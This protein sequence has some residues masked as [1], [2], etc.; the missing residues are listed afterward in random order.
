MYL[1]LDPPQYSYDIELEDDLLMKP[2]HVEETPINRTED[3]AQKLKSFLI[4]AGVPS[5]DEKL[6][7]R[8]LLADST[9][10][11]SRENAELSSFNDLNNKPQAIDLDQSENDFIDAYNALTRASPLPNINHSENIS[12]PKRDNILLNP[13]ADV[14]LFIDIKDPQTQAPISIINDNIGI[15]SINNFEIRQEENALNA[16]NSQVPLSNMKEALNIPTMYSQTQSSR[17]ENTEKLHPLEINKE[18]IGKVNTLNDIVAETNIDIKLS[19]LSN[20]GNN[21]LRDEIVTETLPKLPTPT[22]YED[23]HRN[24]PSNS[25][26]IQDVEVQELQSSSEGLKQLEEE[27]TIN[28]SDIVDNT[29]KLIQQMKE[30]INSDINS[31]DERSKSHSEADNSSNESDFT[32]EHESSYSES[33]VES[34]DLTSDEEGESPEENND[35]KAEKSNTVI[36][37]TSSEENDQFEEAMDHIEEQNENF[38]QTNIEILDSI[39]RSLQEEQSISIEYMPNSQAIHQSQEGHGNSIE[40]IPK[41][42]RNHESPKKSISIEYTPN[43]Q[44]EEPKLSEPKATKP[45]KQDLNNNLFAA[46]NSFEEIYEQ[47]ASPSTSTKNNNQSSPKH[48]SPIK[49]TNL[50]NPE[51]KPKLMFEKH[52]VIVSLFTQKSPTSLMITTPPQP[53]AFNA[54]LENI[55]ENLNA[56]NKTA[57]HLADQHMNM[58]KRKTSEEK[59]SSGTNSDDTYSDSSRKTISPMKETNKRITVNIIQLQNMQEGSSNLPTN[60]NNTHLM[61]ESNAHEVGA[62]AKSISPEKT[63]VQ[64]RDPN[65]KSKSPEINAVNARDYKSKSQS[66]EKTTVHERSPKSKSKTPEKNARDQKSKSKSP[67]KTAVLEKDPR[68]KSESPEKNA[69]TE[70]ELKSKSKS[71]EVTTSNKN[72]PKA[73]SKSPEKETAIATRDINSKNSTTNKS[74]IPKLVKV[75]PNNKQ[76]VDK[77][78]PKVIASKVPVR[79]G[80]LKQYPAPTPPK[81]HFGNVQNGHVKQL[82]TRLFN[83]KPLSQPTAT[84]PTTIEVVAST[85]TTLT[86][87]RPAPLPPG[88]KEEAKQLSPPKTSSPKDKK[89]QYFRETCRT[90]DEWTDSDSEDSPLQISKQSEEPQRVPSPP[91]PITVRRV[92]GQLID[93]A[94][95]RLLEGSPEVRIP[96]YHFGKNDID[97]KSSASFVI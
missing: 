8:G 49:D 47:L 44:V 67:A 72:K 28:L 30:E 10:F 60:E 94:R 93:L 41:N 31:F 5:I 18:N 45:K 64:E 50:V 13:P 86:K 96:Y 16:N 36:D 52:E 21:I 90:E 3:I 69:V 51:Q 33:A 7:L 70:R 39:A 43:T 89:R 38:K 17:P 78:S 82:Q 6:L 26:Y 73:K 88:R 56:E 66:P 79:R 85:S 76:K 61:Q 34:E 42:E 22:N 37:R 65:S 32:T 12:Q 57:G 54:V 46:V 74:N 63:S 25:K 9:L 71:P 27:K 19:S 2:A 80:S 84:S 29:Q 92:S 62:V 1:P 95:V 11:K 83:S 35:V 75:L 53:S 59:E 91:P 55:G 40:Y 97:R 4:Q 68:S 15:P 81:A 87:K 23:P 24:L 77:I 14:H 20:D 48:K 58:Y